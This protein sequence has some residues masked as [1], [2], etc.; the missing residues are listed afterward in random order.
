MLVRSQRKQ[1]RPQR[2][3]ARQIKAP[4]RRSRQR[5]GKLR[6]ST[7]ATSSTPAAAPPPRQ[8]L[9]PRHPKR[10]REHRAKA[11]VPLHQVAQRTRQRRA[12][13]RAPQAAPPA[14]SRSCRRPPDGPGTTAGAAHTTAGSPRDAPRRTSAARAAAAAL[15]QRRA[16][17]RNARRLKQRTDRQLDIKARPHPADQPRRQQRMAAKL[18]EVVVE[19]RPAQAPA[20]PQTDAHSISSARRPRH[21]RAPNPPILRRRQRTAVELAVR[22]QRQ[23]LQ[24]NDRRRHQVLRQNARKRRPKPR[25]VQHRTRRRNHIANQTL[26]PAS[27]AVRIAAPPQ[28]PA[29]HRP[30]AAAQPRSRQAQSGNREA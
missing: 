10:L 12:V 6:R 25:P 23:P 30:A 14:G 26:R 20:P 9:L 19:R 8:N 3:L 2:Q 11:L 1:M 28:Q 7:A 16:K 18:E 29:Q 24:N 22:R 13:K 4:A 5:P 15:Q 17:P 21:A 27:P